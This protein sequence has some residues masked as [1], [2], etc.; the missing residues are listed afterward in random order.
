MTSQADSCINLAALKKAVISQSPFPYTIINNFINPERLADVVQ[1]FPE[2]TSRGSIPASSVKCLPAFQQLVTELEGP[3]FRQ[4]LGEKFSLE[5]KDKPSMLTLRGYTT[6]RDGQIHTDSKTKLITVLLYLNSTWDAE[7]GKL[8]LL[9]SKDSLDDY[10]AEVSP[11]AGNCL[12]FKVTSNGWHGHYPYVGKRLSLQLN[13]LADKEALVK[14]LHHHRFTAFGKRL[15][16]KF[17][18]KNNLTE[19]NY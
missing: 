11:L 18:K 7:Q 16:S 17:L 1:S 19:E 12:I 2:I 10:F 3:E 14:H 5:L 8:R 4:F 9:N 6:E 13:Y 15:L